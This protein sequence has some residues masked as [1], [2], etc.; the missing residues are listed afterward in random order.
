M[1]SYLDITFMKSSLAV[2][3]LLERQGGDRKTRMEEMRKQ[4]IDSRA[5]AEKYRIQGRERFP[6]SFEEALAMEELI[7]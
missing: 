5:S 6:I 3:R 4:Y 7:A 2:Y 1:T